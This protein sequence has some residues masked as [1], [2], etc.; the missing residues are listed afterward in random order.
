MCCD[1]VGGDD[2][3]L[4]PGGGVR[5][6]VGG[7]R[8]CCRWSGL[9]V[10]AR[11]G[12]AVVVVCGS[13]LVGACSAGG[14]EP[15]PKVSK[16]VLQKDI[17]DKLTKG[18]EVPKSV[19][20]KDD[21]VGEVG[22]TTVCEVDLGV[23]G[24]IEPVVKVTGID[25]TKVNY[26]VTPAVSQQQLEKA[27]SA[28]VEQASSATV[29]S[30]SCESGLAGTPEAVAYCTVNSGGDTLRRIVEVTK[31]DGLSMVWMVAPI[32]L[33]A[34]VENTLLNLLERQLGQRPDSASCA[35]NLQGKA[36][37]S[38]ECVVTSGGRTQPFTLTVT[39]VQGSYINFSYQPKR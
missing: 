13:V 23:T 31:V 22:K 35:D 36:G 8:V 2:L 19:I 16:D 9:A 3:S 29:D 7:R 28:L 17:S 1:G 33:K 26:E 5:M 10:G 15:T 27:V 21:L 25:G 32:L 24:S 38:V 18:G 6:A 34:E 20:C 4:P 39:T 30:V 14:V 37:T 11:I 12:V